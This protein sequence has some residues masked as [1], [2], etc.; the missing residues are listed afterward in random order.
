MRSALPPQYG[1]HMKTMMNDTP[2]LLDGIRELSRGD[3]RGAL[4]A[5]ERALCGAGAGVLGALCSARLLILRR[6]HADARVLLE[7]LTATEPGMAEPW[8]MLGC[9]L[10]EQCQTVD[11][12][13]CFREAL[14]RDPSDARAAAGLGEIM[15]AQEP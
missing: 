1:G 14:A 7:R 3:E 12:A 13:R 15:D 9:V 6:R 2:S 10:R 5:F 11:A 8:T 4:A